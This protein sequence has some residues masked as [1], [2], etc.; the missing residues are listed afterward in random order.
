MFS[1][2]GLTISGLIFLSFIAIFYFVKKKYRTLENDIFTVLLILTIILL[3]WEIVCVF[4][5]KNR[6]LFPLL[7]ELICI[8]YIFGVVVWITIIIIYLWTLGKDLKNKRFKDVLRELFIK[9]V[10]FIDLLMFTLSCFFEIEFTSGYNNEL[11]VIR[12]S[13]VSVLYICFAFLC[14][15]ILYILLR[16]KNKI[17]L[18]KR[19]PLFLFI[20]FLAITTIIQFLTFDF[21]DLTF[22][23]S[24]CVMAMYFTIENPDIHLVEELEIANKNAEIANK[25]KT[26]FLSQMSHE[27][28]T[29]L[30]SIMGFSQSII[31][32]KDLTLESLRENS[33]SINNAS[34][35]LLEIVDNILDISKIESSKEKVENIDYSLKDIINELNI[36]VESKI[37]KD[38]EFILNVDE[39]LPSII[40][41]DKTKIYRILNGLISNSIKFTKSG[42]IEL[43]IKGE[44]DKDNI[45]LIFKVSDTGIGIKESD[46]DKLFVKF[47]KINQDAEISSINSTGL[48][49][50]IT[51]ELIDLLDGEISFESNYGVGTKFIV[52]LNNKIINYDKIGKVEL[53]KNDKM[54]FA[55]CSKYNVLL[56]DDNEMSRKANYNLLM[57][58]KFNVTICNSGIECIE[59]I[60]NHEKFDMLVMDFMM[61][62]MDGIET[63]EIVKRL[64]D[65]H[66]PNILVV[67]LNDYSVEEKN[68]CLSK[69]FTDCLAKPIDN[70]SLK[71]LVVK[72][73]M[74][75][76]GDNNV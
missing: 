38:V 40:N 35:N 49:L 73:F 12:G 8:L 15:Y 53:V 45:K 55:D 60:K 36:Y 32:N 69:G 61:P 21:N 54:S 26:E 1:S 48:G 66:I 29:P 5:M 27:I 71:K 20:V 68:K 9:C 52:S 51:K 4:F 7:N 33:K 62:E 25:E 17:S 39:N 57:N 72:Y 41:G 65:Y 24:F 63:I 70:K 67:L 30:N 50:A 13:G 28:R 34:L 18:F 6:I 56:V 44:I 16:N 75:K 2:I 31:N 23:F 10:I 47:N 11:Y 19:L 3:F 14:G 64:N 42:K 76:E 46:F 37:S 74:N 22:L 59:K 43:D 58:Y